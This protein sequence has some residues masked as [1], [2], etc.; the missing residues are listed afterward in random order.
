MKIIMDEI[1]SDN[2][3]QINTNDQIHFSEYGNDITTIDESFF[4]FSFDNQVENNEIFQDIISF[5]SISEKSIMIAI[6]RIS[7]CFES[8]LDD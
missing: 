7:N 3:N 8:F 1:L 4:D 2:N 6:L 5:E